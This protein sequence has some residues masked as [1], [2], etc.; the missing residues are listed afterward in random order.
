MLI[1]MRASALLLVLATVCVYAAEETPFDA[2]QAARDILND[3]LDAEKRE[4]IVAASVPHAADVIRAMTK[5]MPADQGEEY[6]RIPWIWRVSIAAGKQNDATVLRELLKVSLPNK[7][8][9]L[10]DWRAVV[11]GGGIINGISPADG[12]PAE[13]MK[14]LLAAEDDKRLYW[15]R[16]QRTL[17][18]AAAMADDAETPTGTRYDAL[19]ILGATD[20]EASAAVISKYLAADVDEELQQGAVSAAGDIYEA[21]AAD[22]LIN[23]MGAL[24]ERNRSIAIDA[25]METAG[26]RAKLLSALRGGRVRDEWLSPE[27]KKNL[28]VR[29]RP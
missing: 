18:L 11:I 1:L 6:R 25:L 7:D 14:E 24:T 19:R 23:N 13:R 8:E 9:P 28:T 15:P 22:W 26:N 16:W 12:A 27:Q 17:E 5:D 10:D 4:Q 20:W 3:A 2:E 21:A 29:G